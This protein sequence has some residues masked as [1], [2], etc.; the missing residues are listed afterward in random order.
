MIT[1]VALPFDGG[2]PRRQLRPRGDS[3]PG[4]GPLHPVKRGHRYPT[5]GCHGAP[6]DNDHPNRT[7]MP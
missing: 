5:E 4:Y 2:P 7:D 1:Y 6:L 3:L